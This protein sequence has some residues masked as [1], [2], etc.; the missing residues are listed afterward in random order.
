MPERKYPLNKEDLRNGFQTGDSERRVRSQPRVVF[1]TDS[2]PE[3]A[4]DSDQIFENQGLLKRPW[5][6]LMFKPG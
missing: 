1:L 2:N 5:L 4:E 3:K 6:R